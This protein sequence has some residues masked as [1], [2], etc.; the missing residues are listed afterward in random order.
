VAHAGQVIEGQNGY[1]LRIVQLDADLLE[2]EAT[3]AQAGTYP[4]PHF[5][6]RQDERFEVLEGSIKALVDG[7]ERTYGA[8]ESLEVKAGSVHQMTSADGPARMR[9]EA[10][11]SLRLADF[12]ERIHTAPPE[13]WRGFLE[14]FS[15]EIRFVAPDR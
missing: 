10:R 8:G 1:R 7:E 12:F 5:H 13:D 9:W 4:P 6:P 14:S 15:D 11:P 2:M 3:Y